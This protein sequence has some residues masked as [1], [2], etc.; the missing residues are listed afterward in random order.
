MAQPR[1]ALSCVLVEP[2]CASMKGCTM[3]SFN[4]QLRHE[5]TDSQLVLGIVPYN[6]V[7]GYD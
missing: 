7:E 6:L 2:S 1:S 3:M 5:K 4:Q